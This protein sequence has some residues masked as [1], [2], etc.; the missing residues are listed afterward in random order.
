[1]LS[2]ALGDQ[3]EPGTGGVRGGRVDLHAQLGD[4]K[5]VFGLVEVQGEQ[6]PAGLGRWSSTS[7]TASRV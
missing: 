1:M 7:M 3:S 4:S 5:R 6:F 2:Q